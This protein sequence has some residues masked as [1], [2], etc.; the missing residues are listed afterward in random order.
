ME[1]GRLGVWWS[2]SWRGADPSVDTAAELE[3]MGYR[4]LWSSGGFQPGL[5][6]RFGRLLAATERAVVASGIV[7]IWLNPA[8]E[9]AAAVHELS[10]AHPDRFLLGLGVSHGPIVPDYRRPYQRM[11][12]FLDELDAAS[13]TVPPSGRALAALGPRMLRLAAQ[14][15]LGAHPYFVPAEHTAMAREVLGPGPLLAPEVTVVLRPDPG[16]AREIA[17]AFTAR[18]LA[19]PNYADNLRRLGFTDDDVA[20]AGSD[21]LVD[22]VVCWGDPATAAARVRRHFEA[23]ADHV[24]LQVLP[25]EADGFPLAQYRELA[26]ALSDA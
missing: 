9:L 10:G 14:R 13:P 12:R 8:A 23:G 24:C 18:Y 21:R 7:S 19:L 1:L 25:G 6:E 20:G 11:V 2:G 22:A 17:R 15:S 26:A 5:A 16:G 3:A 4:T